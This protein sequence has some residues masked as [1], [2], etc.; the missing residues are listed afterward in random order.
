MYFWNIDALKRDFLQER[1]SQTQAFY[2]LVLMLVLFTLPI[3]VL[4]DNTTVWDKASLWAELA[5]VVFGTTAAYKS[6]GGR[7]GRQFLERYVAL[8][9]VLFIRLL[10]LVILLGIIA[11]IF[12]E[13]FIGD[14]GYSFTGYDFAAVVLIGFF[15]YWRLSHHMGDLSQENFSGVQLG[16]EN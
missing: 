10:P 16:A 12:R 1:F 6:N 14:A 5:L 3:G 13:I 8:S 15:Y 9:W 4:G 2:Y 7:D 11:S